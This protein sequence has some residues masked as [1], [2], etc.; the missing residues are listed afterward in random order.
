MKLHQLLQKSGLTTGFLIGSNT[1][2]SGLGTI[3][4]FLFGEQPS[5]FPEHFKIFGNTLHLRCLTEY[6]GQ[7]KIDVRK[8]E[9]MVKAYRC[10]PVV[11]KLMANSVREQKIYVMV[12]GIKMAMIL[13]IEQPHL[14]QGSDLKSTVCKTLTEFIEKAIEYDYIRQGL[15]YKIGR[16]L[17]NFFFIGLGKN[18]PH[19]VFIFRIEDLPQELRYAKEELDL[20]LYIFKTYGK[21][22]WK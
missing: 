6:K 8:L 19:D 2:H 14:K 4:L 11:T 20:L 5:K 21:P 10:H 7:G 3:K 18:E 1:S 15:T 9:A 12:S 17:K 16:K 13:D 22:I